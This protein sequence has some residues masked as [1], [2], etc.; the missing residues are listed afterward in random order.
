[1]KLGSLGSAFAKDA[2][3]E[4]DGP[5]KPDG[6]V[7]DAETVA[8]GRQMAEAALKPQTPGTQS[9]GGDAL[10]T[11]AERTDAS[12]RGMVPAAVEAGAD[13]GLAETAKRGVV[14]AIAS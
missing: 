1:W 6:D 5:G 10:K 9:N 13:R 11:L 3:A 14:P 4:P 2:P 7:A 12:G 8:E